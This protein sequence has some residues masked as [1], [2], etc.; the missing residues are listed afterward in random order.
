MN[1][2]SEERLLKEFIKV[3][4]D[5]DKTEKK[6]IRYTKIA[7]FVSILI[8]FFCLSNGIDLVEQKYFFLICAFVSGMIFGLSL[9]FMQAGTQTKVMVKHMSKESV[10]ARINEINT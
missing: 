3:I 10:N 7:M 8:I 2:K 9:W 4:D 1:N 6:F 5:P